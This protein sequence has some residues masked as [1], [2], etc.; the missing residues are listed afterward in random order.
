M[1][2]EIAIRRTKKCT[3]QYRK[4][5]VIVLWFWKSQLY[6]LTHFNFRTAAND[7]LRK[8]TRDMERLI[9]ELESGNLDL[10]NNRAALVNK[11][12]TMAASLKQKQAEKENLKA[13]TSKSKATLAVKL[14]YYVMI[15]IQILSSSFFHP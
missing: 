14:T 2:F 4:N 10:L 12:N 3:L 1:N 5:K 9:A 15:C 8:K 11:Q 7:E 13:A 6:R